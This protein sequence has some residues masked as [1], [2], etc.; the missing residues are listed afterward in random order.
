M[1]VALL[2]LLVPAVGVQKGGDA[3]KTFRDF[4]KKIASAKAL[5]V[6][7]DVVD[8]EK[9][10]KF[11]IA[12]TLAQGN[13]ARLNL[14]GEVAGRELTL[15]L[16]CDGTNMQVTRGEGG[17]RTGGGGRAPDHFTKMLGT[18]L[19][20]VGVIGSVRPE[21]WRDRGNAPD[22]EK[23]FAL[24]IFKA[25]TAEK[26][27][28]RQ[29]RVVHYDVKIRGKDEA[30]VTLWLDAATMLPVK[31]AIVT[32]SGKAHITETYKEFNLNPTLDAN[33][34]ELSR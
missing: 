13:K 29:T 24:S 27:N 31:R 8:K 7:A 1:R 28:D 23:M 30:K 6:V 32:D 3:E 33:T 14:R 26:V 25:G 15:D 16:V 18:V 17:R 22:L 5:H 4:E 10:A 11:Q 9:E 21:T 12:L 2:A 34:F 20:R 19:S